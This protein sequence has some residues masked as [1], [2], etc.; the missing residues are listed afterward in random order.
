M[1]RTAMTRRRFAPPLC[2]LIVSLLI[3]LPIMAQREAP[4]GTT[5]PYDSARAAPRAK[6][7]ALIVERCAGCHGG[8]HP[9]KGLDLERGKIVAS[10]KDVPSR[11]I[12]SLMIVDS[13]RPERSYFLMKIRGDKGI[14]GSRMP[15]GA[16]ALAPEE[17]RMIEHWIR[18]ISGFRRGPRMRPGAPDGTRRE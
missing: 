18:G 14:K 7:V 2:A 5:A 16:P 17:I 10:V 11:E 13:R 8:M 9:A 6:T 1:I 12:D 4:R 3:S 15:M